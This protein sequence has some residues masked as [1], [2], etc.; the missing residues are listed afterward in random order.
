MVPMNTRD[1]KKIETEKIAADVEANLKL[2]Y[3]AMLN[4]LN[5]L[6]RNTI[7]NQMTNVRT[8]MWVNVVYIGISLKL[9]NYNWSFYLLISLVIISLGLSFYA[10]VFGRSVL[11]G[12]SQR[13]GFMHSIQ[14][15][16]W[17]KTTGLY[18][19]IHNVQRAIRYNGI[20][21]IKRS[22]I[23]RNITIVTFISLLSLGFCFAT[24]TKENTWQKDQL[25]VHQHQVV[26]EDEV[27]VQKLKSKPH[28][29][30]NH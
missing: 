15:G 1:R 25:Q 29:L 13:K 12:N 22:R 26:E 6:I 11:Y 16:V 24:N 14:D 10:M 8:L 9:S 3:D 23:I 5:T 21:V 4:E 7:P 27:I 18:Y 2:H 17:A 20:I 19:M 30:L 28:G